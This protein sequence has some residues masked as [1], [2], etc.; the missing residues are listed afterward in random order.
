MRQALELSEESDAKVQIGDLKLDSWQ[1][2]V[3]ANEKMYDFLL[4]FTSEEAFKL[5]EQVSG[6]GFEAWRQLKRRYAP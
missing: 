1:F 6:D 3:E 5:V 4:T 2:A